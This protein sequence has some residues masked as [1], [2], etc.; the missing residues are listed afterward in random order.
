MGFGALASESVKVTDQMFLR[1]AQTLAAQTSAEDLA[2]GRCYPALSHIREVQCLFSSHRLISDC[3]RIVLNC[4]SIYGTIVRRCPQRSQRRWR[5]RRTI[6]VSRAASVP[7]I[8]SLTSS[9]GCSFPSTTTTSDVR[10]SLKHLQH[11]TQFHYSRSYP[12]RVCYMRS[13]P[14]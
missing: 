6:R 11:S 14:F 8:C 13:L 7:P 1:A 2:L 9:R 12:L 4:T 5:T 3:S 10:V